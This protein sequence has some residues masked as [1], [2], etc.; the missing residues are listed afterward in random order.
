[1]SFEPVNHGI[2]CASGLKERLEAIY[3]QYNRRKYV[4]PDPLQFL[5][6]YNSP[7]DQELVG[8]VAAGLAYGRVETIVRSCE[9]VLRP[10]GESP[11]KTLLSMDKSALL[12]T[13]QG[14]KHR[15]HQGEHV[16]N[17]LFNAGAL[18]KRYRSLGHALKAFVQG[19]DGDFMKGLTCLVDALNS[20]SSSP[21]LLPSP[22]KGSACKRLFLYLRW[23]I[24]KDE[25]DP[26]CWHGLFSPGVLL[27]PLDTHLF[28]I[29]KR[30]GFTKR[31]C[32]DLRAA[33]EITQGFRRLSPLDPVRYDFSLT[34]FGINPAFSK[35]ELF[36][37]L[38]KS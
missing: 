21:F 24:R 30:L 34:R 15:F 11:S 33:S 16:A 1:M 17:L 27:V 4:P 29:G 22:R 18:I 9:A 25:V 8:L 31:R 37:L 20:G 2:V 28:S 10:L 26:G 5:Y 19:A 35:E 14:F 13:Y 3:H 7:L 38:S 12:A 23:M 36:C 32:A 6:D